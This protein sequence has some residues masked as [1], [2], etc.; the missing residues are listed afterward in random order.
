MEVIGTDEFEG[1]FLELS[2]EDARAVLNVTAK[3]EAGGISLGYPHSSAIQG[4]SFGLRELRPQ[5]GK[6]PIRVFYA[7]DPRRDAI[8][9]IGGDKSGDPKFYDRMRVKCEA[10]WQQYL[11]EQ[12]AGAHDEE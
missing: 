8:L 1:W 3:L 4:S 9:I 7:F 2:D 6:S 10:V 12:R 5:A 11:S